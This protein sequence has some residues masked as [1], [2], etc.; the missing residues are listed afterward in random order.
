L[1]GDETHDLAFRA[2]RFRAERRSMSS[3]IVLA[4]DEPRRIDAIMAHDRGDDL[5]SRMSFM[6]V[7]RGPELGFADAEIERDGFDLVMIDATEDSTNPRC[8]C[9]VVDGNARRL[10]QPWQDFGAA[11]Q[12]SDARNGPRCFV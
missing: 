5:D 11:L 3:R 8:D 1:L 2:L 6:W 7:E 4:G 9:L 12:R 10:L